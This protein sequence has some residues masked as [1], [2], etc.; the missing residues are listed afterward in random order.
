[1]SQGHISAS[2]AACLSVPLTGNSREAEW[3][4]A[5]DFVMRHFL[6]PS[7]DGEEVYEAER[8]AE[9]LASKYAP[10]ARP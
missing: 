4:S 7:V 10:K 3:I 6:R 5:L 1:M 8:V 2:E 9:W